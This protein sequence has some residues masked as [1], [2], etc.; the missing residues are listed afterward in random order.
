MPTWRKLYAKI[1]D[2]FDVN[3]MPD[4]F[5]RLLWTWLPIALDREGRGIYNPAWVKARVMPLREDVTNAQVHEALEWYRAQGMVI[6]YSANG[7]EYFYIPTWHEY[8]GDTSREG[9][10][11]YPEPDGANVPPPPKL[12]QDFGD[13]AR[14]YE[15]NI[16]IIT[17]TTADMLDA[18]LKEYGLI[19]CRDAIDEAARQN[20]RSWAYVQGILKRWKTDG[21]G[22]GAKAKGDLVSELFSEAT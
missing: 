17:P 7:R 20:K 21:R 2:S 15:K 9:E 8:Q 5:T 22:N 12:D 14:H 19:F 6:V 10:A 4:D 11:R 3:L 1:V 16:G 18:D 13:L